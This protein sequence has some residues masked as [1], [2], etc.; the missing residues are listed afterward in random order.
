MP[1]RSR[2][3]TK[4]NRRVLRDDCCAKETDLAIPLDRLRKEIAILKKCR[5]PNVVR[6]REV[7]DAPASKKIYLGERPSPC[8]ALKQFELTALRAS[9]GIL[10][11][12]GGAVED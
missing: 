7:I 9:T 1:N 10:R 8:V 5:H 6:L 4:S 3:R 11:G 2:L 12:R